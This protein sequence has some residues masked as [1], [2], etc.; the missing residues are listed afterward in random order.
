MIFHQDDETNGDVL[1]KD[2]RVERHSE[3]KH[4]DKLMLS[5]V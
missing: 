3:S 2:S 4:V 1:F 5:N